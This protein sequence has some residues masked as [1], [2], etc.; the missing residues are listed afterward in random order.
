M[1]LSSNRVNFATSIAQYNYV[2]LL[3]NNRPA[4]KRILDIVTVLGLHTDDKAR[5]SVPN[6]SNFSNKLL[7]QSPKKS[8]LVLCTIKKLNFK[9]NET[10]CWL[11]LCVNVYGEYVNMEVEWDI[12]KRTM[13]VVV[14]GEENNKPLWRIHVLKVAFMTNR[15][16]LYLWL[17][18]KIFFT[19]SLISTF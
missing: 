17:Y 8:G 12:R 13:T 1:Q 15:S 19:T 9:T 4:K 14:N 18:L 7:K 3:C 10:K 6:K 2:Q 5:F 11:T 16:K